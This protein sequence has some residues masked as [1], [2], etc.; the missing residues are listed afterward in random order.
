M[1]TAG[2]LRLHQFPPGIYFPGDPPTAVYYTS[3]ASLPILL[4]WSCCVWQSIH[5]GLLASKWIGRRVF[6]RPAEWHC[7]IYWFRTCVTE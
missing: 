3:L 2:G 1:L 6:Q 4:V 5:V 7:V